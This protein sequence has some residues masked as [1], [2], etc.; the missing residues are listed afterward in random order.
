M[1]TDRR[2]PNLR[3]G[4]LRRAQSV[5]PFGVG[6]IMDLPDES[7]M[8]AALDRWGSFGRPIH[9]ARLEKRLGVTHFRMAPSQ[10]ESRNGGVPFVRF[11]RWLFCQK[12][13]SFRPVEEWA[14]QY[15][16]SHHRDFT[17]PVCDLCKSRLV[18]S[19]FIVICEKGHIDDFPWIEW[20][21]GDAVCNKPE[22]KIYT[23]GSSSGLTGI[24][25]ECTSCRKRRTMAGAFSSEAHRSCKGRMPWLGRSEA[26]DQKPITVQRGASN[27]YFPRVATSIAIPPYSDSLYRDIQESSGWH[28]L[29]T[30]DGA[31]DS[32]FAERIIQSIA[33]E[34]GRTQEEVRVAVCNLL[35][36]K[37]DLQTN[38]VTEMQYRYDEYRAFRQETSSTEEAPGD[39]EVELQSG[40]EYSI[41]G[42]E[43]VTLVHRLREVRALTGFSRVKP[44]DRNQPFDDGIVGNA[45]PAS[46]ANRR[47]DWLP[48]VEVRGEGVFLQFDCQMLRDW[49]KYEAVDSR[50]QLLCRRYAIMAAERGLLPRRI[51]PAFVFLHT[52]AHLL[53]R[54]LSFECGY[55]SASLRER[56]Y[57]SEEPG[58]PEM[59][60]I[61]IYTASGDSDGTLGGLVRQGKPGFLD[62][63]MARAIQAASWCSSD[64]LCIE[65][66]GQGMGALNLAACHACALLPETSC[67]EFNRLLDRGLVIGLPEDPTV[68]FFGTHKWI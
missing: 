15:R 54:G 59:A 56:L 63:V 16:D 27:V 53:I 12:C 6:S 40:E 38:R 32:E 47:L 23:E 36:S 44:I 45:S 21:H 7:V 61:L 42:L 49:S 4:V 17:T 25:V 30:Q 31:I 3:Y 2:D 18:P 66:P 34:I 50:A 22:L 43:S 65:S 60:G 8:A 41:P 9:E 48:G 57:C 46:L 26:C 58:D 11:P 62:R 10:D 39:F 33:K 13:R 35:G 37:G 29:S 19:R 67:E 52:V 24:S 28:V 5:V 1:R 64:P 14:Q 68:G 55:G 20:V 51:S